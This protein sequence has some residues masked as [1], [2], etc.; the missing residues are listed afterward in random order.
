MEKLYDK[1]GKSIPKGTVIFNEGESG[2]D[3][4]I[5][6]EGKV[7]ISKKARSIETTLAELSK[8]DFFGEMA[9][10]E[11]GTRSAT[12]VALTDLKVLVLDEKTFE[13]LLMSNPNVALRMMKKM[14]ERLRSADQRIETLLF[15]DATSKVVDMISKIANEKGI[16]SD[17]GM[18]VK[19]TVSD[20]AGRVGLDIDKTRNVLDSL[21]ERKFLL[22]G[23]DQLTIRN[24]KSLNKILSYIELKE[25]LGDII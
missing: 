14:A 10:L 24:P 23:D 17:K 13:S 5:I 8:G 15:K 22:L 25:Q 7:K 4:F 2:D 11:R 12:A 18:V 19:I 3:M 16:E 1:F 9:I 21:V 6:H 20:L